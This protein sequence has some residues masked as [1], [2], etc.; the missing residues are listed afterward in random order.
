MKLYLNGRGMPPMEFSRDLHPSHSELTADEK[1]EGITRVVEGL[2]GLQ[3]N[4]KPQAVIV[5]DG[6]IVAVQNVTSGQLIWLG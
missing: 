6:L 5:D 1:R 2:R 3:G 4:P